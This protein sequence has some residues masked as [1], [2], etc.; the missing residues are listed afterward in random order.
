MNLENELWH[1]ALKLYADK[2]VESGCLQL[3]DAGLS[4]NRVIYCIWL[5]LQ[6]RQ[7]DL[8]ATHDADTWQS[9]VTHP[10]RS[11]RYQ[12]RERKQGADVYESCYSAM[13]QAEL[14]CEQ[15]ELAFLHDAAANM[16]PATPGSA[17]VVENLAR[18]LDRCTLDSGL[19]ICAIL[20]QVLEAALT[21][22]PDH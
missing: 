22:L 2:D 1:Y 6:G 17:L 21:E 5:G 12:V 4:I 18:Y 11:L 15:L 13:R 3:Q 7:L 10:M 8:S 20:R 9:T 14:A 16:I 19:N